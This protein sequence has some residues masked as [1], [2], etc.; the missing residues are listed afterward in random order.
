MATSKA[1][2]D[3]VRFSSGSDADAAGF[4]GHE[5]GVAGFAGSSSELLGQTNSRCHGD[6]AGRG[7]VVFS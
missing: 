1:G 5:V 2:D 3:H 4:A 7:D 6:V